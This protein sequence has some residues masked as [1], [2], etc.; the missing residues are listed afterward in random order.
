MPHARLDGGPGHVSGHH[1][2]AGVTDGDNVLRAESNL[3][4]VWRPTNSF[5]VRKLGGMKSSFLDDVIMEDC[6]TVLYQGTARAASREEAI[7][8][9]GLVII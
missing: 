7:T 8:I 2:E 1:L 6:V 5:E 3:G 9:W 4:L